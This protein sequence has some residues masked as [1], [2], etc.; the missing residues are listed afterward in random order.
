[1]TTLTAASVEQ[2]PRITPHPSKGSR[3][4]RVLIVDDA[5]PVRRMLSVAMQASGF[6]VWLASSSR[7][8]VALFQQYCVAIDIVLLDVRIR[9]GPE[10]L[11]A[12][13]EFDPHIRFCFMSGDMG[14]YTETGLVE[15]GAAFVFQ[16]PLRLNELSR[17][18]GRLVAPIDRHADFQEDRWE[19]D[20]GCGRVL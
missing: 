3:P 15:L 17:Q 13:R 12:L 6:A 10:T 14:R 5:E 18:L 1:M 19:D 8:A 11:A 16:K 20:G 4:R 7:E 9:D 2:D